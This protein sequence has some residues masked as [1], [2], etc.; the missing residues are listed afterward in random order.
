MTKEVKILLK[1][2]TKT[3]WSWNGEQ[4]RARAN[5]RN[6]VSEKPEELLVFFYIEFRS[7]CG[8]LFH[9]CMICHLLLCRQKSTLEGHFHHPENDCLPNS[10]PWGH[11]RRS[12]PQQSD[13]HTKRHRV[14]NP[15]I[16]AGSDGVTGRVLVQI[17]AL[18][19]SQRFITCLSLNSWSQHD[20]SLQQRMPQ[21][22]FF[23]KHWR[24]M[25]GF[26]L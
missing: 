8:K 5:M 4:R 12:L 3:S 25:W 22:H 24:A 6:E 19:S 2:H 7:K 11:L 17:S 16:A 26:S 9:L 18:R 20:L 23:K 15:R 13:Q 1:D 10:L 21:S 14:V